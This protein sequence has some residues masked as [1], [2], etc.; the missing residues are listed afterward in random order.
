MALHCRAEAS[1]LD[2]LR[3][4]WY[5]D[6][7][8]VTM[9]PNARIITEFMALH[10]I[11]TMPQDAGTYYCVA[12]NSFGRTQSRTAKVQFLSMFYRSSSL[13]SNEMIIFVCRI[14]QRLSHL[15]YVNNGFDRRT[16]SSSL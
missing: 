15:S 2:D 5:K 7:R 6:G 4:N 1:S 13:E 11:N 16:C 12:E 9:D 14:R 8:L 10:I 3:V